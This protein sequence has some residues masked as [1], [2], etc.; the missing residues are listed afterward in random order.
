MIDRMAKKSTTPILILALIAGISYYIAYWVSI[1]P[2]IDVIWKGSGVALLAAWA[3]AN[4]ENWIGSVLAFG[5]LGDV[6]LETHGLVAGA[7]AFMTGHFMATGFYWTRSKIRG[8]KAIVTPI[9]LISITALASF[10][11]TQDPLATFYG[12]VLGLMAGIAMISV[13]PVAALGTLSFIVSDLFL[14]G[15]LANPE[16]KTFFGAFVWPTYFAA[17]ALVAWGVVRVRRAVRRA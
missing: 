15:A 9:I 4:R 8:R 1:P 12:A 2:M 11:I 3:F 14:F 17:Q 6:L 16:S 5:A 10:F 7:V 13:Y